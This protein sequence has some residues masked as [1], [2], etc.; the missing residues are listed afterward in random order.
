METYLVSG[1]GVSVICGK[2][3]VPYWINEIV[4]RGG[5]PTVQRLAQSPEGLVAA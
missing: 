2:S 3:N 4:R 1:C 5:V